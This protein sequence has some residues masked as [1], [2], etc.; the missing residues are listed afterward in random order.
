MLIL[1]NNQLKT[2]R[3]LCLKRVGTAKEW[4]AGRSQIQIN[5]EMADVLDSLIKMRVG[6]LPTQV[7]QDS[8]KWAN[9]QIGTK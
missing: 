6:R 9:S 3:V 1:V 5:L 2:A 4:V 8:T 7:L